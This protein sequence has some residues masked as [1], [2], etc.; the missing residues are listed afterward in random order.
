MNMIPEQ[1]SIEQVDHNHSCRKMALQIA[2]DMKPP[3]NYGN[4][5]AG[6]LPVTPHYDLLKEAELIYQWLIKD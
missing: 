2:R 3:T 1:Q 4:P 6:Q 5:L